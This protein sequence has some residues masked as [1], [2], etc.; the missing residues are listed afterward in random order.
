VE[1]AEGFGLTVMVKVVVVEQPPAVAVI[2]NVL[3]IGDDVVLVVVKDAT[4][5]PPLVELTPILVPDLV[6]LIVAPG[7]EL[8]QETPPAWS[9]EHATW[10]A[11]V[12]NT[13][14]GLIMIVL[15]SVLVPHSFVTA[16]DTFEVPWELKT[17]VPGLAEEEPEGVPE[18]KLQL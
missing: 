12:D 4:E 8:V 16:T 5:L 1:G 7:V 14:T 10:L 11:A 9:P 13:G 3:T 6:Q 18:G 15:L 2:V 17:T